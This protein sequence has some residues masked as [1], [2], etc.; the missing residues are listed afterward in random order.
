MSMLIQ[1]AIYAAIAGA[2]YLAFTSWTDSI[3]KEGAEAQLKADTPIINAC[4][5]DRDT[6]VKANV[7]LQADV[8]R[9]EGERQKQNDAVQSLADELGE[10][11]KRQAQMLAAAKPR[12]AALRADSGTLE[13]R[14]AANT[15]G[16]SC[17]ERLSNVDSDLRAIVGGVRPT[18]TT[19]TGNVRSPN[20][21]AGTHSGRG[22]L[23][24]SK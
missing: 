2:A 22:T 21:P 11:K 7:S 5:V 16:K 18:G 24:L 1:I 9:I 12:I 19:P 10:Q 14:L 17:D 15:E 4:K 23:R 6:A 3:R 20:P 8:T 13:Q